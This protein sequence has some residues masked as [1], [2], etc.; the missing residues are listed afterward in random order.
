[1]LKKSRQF[2]IG[3]QGAAE[4]FRLL[5]V[6][7]DNNISF[8]EFIAPILEQIPPRVAICFV[9]DIRFKM[10]V[11]TNLRHAYRTVAQ[12]SDVVTLDLVKGKLMD[13]QDSLAPHFVKAIDELRLGTEEQLNEKGFM[14]EVARMEKHCLVSFANLIFKS[15]DSSTADPDLEIVEAIKAGIEDEE[16]EKDALKDLLRQSL[17]LHTPNVDIYIPPKDR[18]TWMRFRNCTSAFYE[19]VTDPVVSMKSSAE[20]FVA[21]QEMKQ[22]ILE[23]EKDIAENKSYKERFEALEKS[24][25]PEFDKLFV[26]QKKQI[27][28]ARQD[29]INLRT[30]IAKQKLSIDLYQ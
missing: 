30:D 28:M 4:Y 15:L 18:N 7:G 5:D 6:D 26:T 9:S 2:K 3:S 22:Y 16:I 20:I 8:N 27:A 12:I 25:G 24:Q 10:E 14:R 21:N 23:L 17:N 11:Y 1:M 29:N 13:R 19:V